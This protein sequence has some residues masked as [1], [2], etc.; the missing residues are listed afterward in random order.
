MEDAFA[1][2]VLDQARR[3]KKQIFRALLPSI[4]ISLVGVFLLGF[5]L[6]AII[7]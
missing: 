6:G 2:M 7:F 4:I 3:A 5:I 1:K